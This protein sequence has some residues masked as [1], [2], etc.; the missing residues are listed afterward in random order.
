MAETRLISKMMNLSDTH[1]APDAV[2]VP[3]SV[4]AAQYGEP[5]IPTG[6]QHT[7]TRGGKAVL[8]ATRQGFPVFNFYALDTRRV[9][10]AIGRTKKQTQTT[11]VSLSRLN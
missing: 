8:S 5:E 2:K 9:A 7:I 3:P 1:D 10:H 4:F 11:K 6:I